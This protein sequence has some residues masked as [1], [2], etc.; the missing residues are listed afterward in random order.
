MKLEQLFK[1]LFRDRLNTLVIII[2]LAVGM[3][4]LNLIILFITRELNTDSFQKD[5][6]RIYMLKC[7]DPFNKGSRM[8]TCKSGAAEYIKANF[9]QVEDYCRINTGSA[10]KIIVN[11]QSF[12]DDPD[13]YGASANF[14]NF[15]SYQL[16]TNNPNTALA[17]KQDIVISEEL[18]TKYFGKRKV[19]GQTI[20]LVNSNSKNDYIITGIFRRPEEN[21]QLHFDMVK[22]AE[23]SERFA[24]LKLKENTDPAELERIF[25]KE[26]NKIPGIFN[27]TPGKYYLESLKDAYFDTLGN[28]HLGGVREK[29]DLLIAFI[30]GLMIIVVASFNYLGLINNKLLDNTREFNIRRINGGTKGNLV[31]GF[32]IENLVIIVIAFAL[33]LELMSVLLPFFNSLVAADIQIRLLFQ[34]NALFFSLGVIAFLLLVTW[35][36]SIIKIKRQLISSTHND[37]VDYDGKK[38][39]IPAFNIL[40][41]TISLV[42]LV[43]SF[44]IMKQINYISNKEIGIDKQVIEVKL[45]YK[46]TDK[47]KVFR[48]EILKNPAIDL[49]SVTSASPLLEYIM[50]LYHY[51]ENGKELEYAP[52]ILRGDENYINTLGISLISGRN[53]SGTMASDFNSCLI[54]ETMERKFPGKNL[55]GEKLPGDDRFT[56]IGI[57]KDFNYYSLKKV[58]EPTIITCDTAGNHLLVKASPGQLQQARK[59]ITKAWQRLVPDSPPDLESVIERYEWY[60]REN[61]NYAKLIVSCCFI[62]LFLS[63]IGLFALSF[64]A[65]RK[66]T[67]EIGIRKI[68]GATIWEV[69][70]MLNMDFVR[71]VA[72]AFIVSTPIAWYFMH[73]WLENFAYKTD[74]SWWIFALAGL[75]TMG[76]VLIT[77][78]WQSWRA[79]TRNPVEALRYE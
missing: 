43:G 16:L 47:V 78:S 2:S 74:L 5:V 73:K 59:A 3:A 12:D 58:I 69:M 45:P 17:T 10:L 4:S 20:T 39:R 27:E 75:L 79:A 71:W 68:N 23:S 6:D 66:R 33:S 25:A 40:Q 55:L 65:S 51:T 11:G 63:V 42:L 28:S 31:A 50:V 38:I 44:I 7:D 46:Y 26:K 34:T 15:F 72:I 8:S 22:F 19:V 77:V 76:I 48:E 61:T 49:V 56:I 60:H 57:V 1:R 30:I 64:H 32:M 54:N 21:T 67:K 37:W 41:L 36:F 29:A 9:D 62:S 13:I 24:F 52:S 35:V 70:A 53:F 18:A 14:F